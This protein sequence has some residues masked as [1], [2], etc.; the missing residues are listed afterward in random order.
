MTSRDGW[1]ARLTTLF[2]EGARDET[3]HD[4]GEGISESD[5][6]LIEALPFERITTHGNRA[7]AEWTRLRREGRFY[8]V[9][10]GGDEELM[11][12]TEQWGR[13]DVPPEE[14]LAKAGTLHHPDSLFAL[15]EA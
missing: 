3:W 6:F 2:G 14:I 15:R 5:R 9:I 8:P 13:D 4:L 12:L 10:V 11:R 1:F 7:M